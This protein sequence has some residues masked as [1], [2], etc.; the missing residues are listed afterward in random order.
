MP[1]VL[2]ASVTLRWAFAVSDPY[3]S[4][5][6]DLLVHDDALTPSIWPLEVSN[7][8]LTGERHGYLDLAHSTRFLGLL[9]ELPV[10]V[11]VTGA[12]LILGTILELARAQHLSSYDAAYLELA[13]REGISLASADAAL[14]DAA[15][16]VGVPLVTGP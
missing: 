6:R 11:E 13:M 8:I 10:V 3:A 5:V 14:R 1:F 9:R 15:R 16:R 12:E 7:G 2:D 4:Y